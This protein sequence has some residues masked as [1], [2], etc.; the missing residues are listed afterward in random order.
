MKSQIMSPLFLIFLSMQVKESFF[1]L[2]NNLT[3]QKTVIFPHAMLQR[4]KNFY[5][6]LNFTAEF[7]LFFSKSTYNPWE[8]MRKDFQP[9]TGLKS[10]RVNFFIKN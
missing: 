2:S 6:T 9:C 1:S 10:K 8:I 3:K 4:T 7:K 5:I